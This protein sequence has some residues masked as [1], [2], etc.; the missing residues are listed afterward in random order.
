MGEGGRRPDISVVIAA[1]NIERYIERA[2]L[3]AL[4]QQGVEVEVLVVDDGSS[5]GTFAAARRVADPRVTVLR[6]DGNRGPSVARNLAFERAAAPWLAVLD[7]DDTWQPGR[8]ARCLAVARRHAADIVVD[9]LEAR[10]ELD[11]TARIMFDPAFLGGPVLGLAAFIRGNCA[12]LG[13]PS[14]GYVKPV[15]SAEFLRGRNLSY[16]PTLRIGEDYMLLADALA[17]GAVCAVDPE[18]GYIYTVRAG[19]ISHRLTSADVSRIIDG[20]QRFKARHALEEDALAALN[21]RER[22]LREALQF[23]D[24]VAALKA[25]SFAR[26]LRLA[27]RRPGVLWHMRHAVL[28]RVRALA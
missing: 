5:D 2:I 18:A 9:N 14:L 22:L 8:L 12:F 23:T 15:F 28:N 3:S 7:G 24:L 26:A 1:Y 13:G 19:S 11:G 25:R 6:T 4:D 21:R 10:A 16:D 20:D 27:A 17:E